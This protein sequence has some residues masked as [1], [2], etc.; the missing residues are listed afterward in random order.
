MSK[1]GPVHVIVSGFKDCPYYQKAVAEGQRYAAAHPDHLTITVVEK[2][3]PQ[4]HEYREATLKNLG[5]NPDSHKTCPLV[6]THVTN[7]PMDF[8]GGCDSFINFL[9][10]EFD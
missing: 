1:K 2:P 9:R 3:R 5:K 10:T 8:I 7:K 6:F 4:F